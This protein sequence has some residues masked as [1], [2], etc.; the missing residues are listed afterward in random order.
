MRAESARP[1]VSA[2]KKFVHLLCIAEAAV[3]AAGKNVVSAPSHQQSQDAKG[4]GRSPG[5]AGAENE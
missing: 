5:G 3:W 4:A 1:Q 2:R